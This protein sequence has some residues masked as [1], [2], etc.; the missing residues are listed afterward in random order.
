MDNTH[1]SNQDNHHN[2]FHIKKPPNGGFQNRIDISLEPSHHNLTIDKG[3]YRIVDSRCSSHTIF[4][5]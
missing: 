3:E 2:T 5:A 1:I 4:P